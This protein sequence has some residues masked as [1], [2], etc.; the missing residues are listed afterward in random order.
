MLPVGMVRNFIE[1]SIAM[2]GRGSV[3][4]GVLL[5]RED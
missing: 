3:A 2:N 4:D 1:I 5:L